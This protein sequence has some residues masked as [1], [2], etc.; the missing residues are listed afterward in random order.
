MRGGR[1][2]GLGWGTKLGSSTTAG[3]GLKFSE[4]EIVEEMDY[5]ASSRVFNSAGKPSMTQCP[6]H[7]SGQL[8]VQP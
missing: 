2:V 5:I 6:H 4:F 8:L 7:V 1:R 3:L